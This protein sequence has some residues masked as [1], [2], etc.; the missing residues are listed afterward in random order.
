VKQ[1]ILA[2]LALAAC[3]SSQPTERYGFITRLGQDTISVES[4]TRRGNTLASDE[5]DRFPRVRQRHTE[6]TVGPDGGIQHLV[7]DIVTPS[8]P[9]NQRQRHIV[10]DVTKDSVLMTKRDGTGT[11]RWAYAT[12][13][14]TVMA[15]VPQMYSLYELYF[16][17]GLRRLASTPTPGDTA[18]FR[19]FYIDRE[20]DRFSLHHGTV[21]RR[22]GGKPEIWHD[23]LAG[24]GEATVDS[25][26]R[27]LHYSG[28]RTTYKVDVTRVSDVPNVQAIGAQMAAVETKNGGVTQLS[29]RDTTR[30]T[31]GSASF[32]VDYGR[33]LARGRQL[34]G[35]II[36]Y[37]DVWRT[38][39]NAATQFTTSAPIT[40]A[41][42]EVPAGTY[43][44]WTRPH[45]KGVELIVN[46]QAGQW[47]TE[48]DARRD[49]G[50]APMQTETLATPAERFTIAITA[51]DDRHGTFT[52]QW[53]PFQWTAPIVLDGPEA[54]GAAPRHA[55]KRTVH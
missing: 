30:A 13:G 4:V 1:F 2:T 16:A 45:E 54:R 19:Q 15:H 42:L 32:S 37:N 47:G 33:P 46:K 12:G 38:G 40:L 34:L 48:Y 36:P 8:E 52:M 6:I 5:A 35:D 17:A 24:I 10:A 22:P 49:L 31:I 9:A 43:T 41:G 50:R 29:V 3:A 51:K 39:A 18:E 28:A 21:H 27:M 55:P 25:A 20:F 7:M 11:K 14:A 26:Y 53:G 23:W 44:L